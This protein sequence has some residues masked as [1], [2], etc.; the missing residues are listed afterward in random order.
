MTGMEIMLDIIKSVREKYCR[1]FELGDDPSLRQTF[2]GELNY[3]SGKFF[4]GVFIALFIWLPYITTDL[5]LHQYPLMTIY[6]RI[7]LTL[8]SVVLIVL[9]VTGPLK[10]RP[11]IVMAVLMGYLFLTTP[12][13][14]ATAGTHAVAY[15][16]GYTFV[17]MLVLIFPLSFRYK[18][19]LLIG[20]LAIFF[21]CA[22]VFNLNFSDGTIR[23]ALTDSVGAVVVSIILSNIS[24][25]LRYN[26]WQQRRIIS[27]QR[28]TIKRITGIEADGINGLKT[29]DLFAAEQ[30]I[31][32]SAT[33]YTKA[34]QDGSPLDVDE[35]DKLVKEYGRLLRQLRRATRISDRATAGLSTSKVDLQG[36][37]NFDALTG[38]YNR[39]YLDENIGR[40]V[41]S[42][43]RSGSM[44]S[45]MMMDIDYFKKYNDTYGHSE[46]D[47]CLKAVAKAIAGCVSRPDDFA[48]RYGGEE[49][50]VILPGTDESGARV[51]AE[52]I[53]EAVRALGIPHEK[54]MPLGAS[55][56]P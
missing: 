16:G 41:K 43:A 27:K 45:V 8:L 13:I 7:G 3:D 24:D 31:F 40:V 11:D 6:M 23:Y 53:L 50:A 22:V 39:R 10:R 52:K 38:L 32:E 2:S 55:P 9:K 30:S 21:A 14:T 5:S 51:M 42:A 25:K 46:G 29:E 49:F 12:I 15:I 34:L 54:M 48:V 26:S 4:F 35:F 36:K 18:V 37:V 33:A 20:S 1:W 56:F 44:L 19:C 47:E 17:I 28:E